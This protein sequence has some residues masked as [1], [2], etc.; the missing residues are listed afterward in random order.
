MAKIG[1]WV[2][3]L[4]DGWLSRKVGGYVRVMGG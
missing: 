3:K 2:A 4:G 1:K